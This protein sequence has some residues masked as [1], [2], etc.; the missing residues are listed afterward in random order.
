M[1]KIRNPYVVFGLKTLKGRNR[2]EDFRVDC[3]FLMLFVT[4]FEDYQN[5]VSLNHVTF[6]RNVT[7]ML[8]IRPHICILGLMRRR[9]DRQIDGEM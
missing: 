6:I 7:Y 9:T 3:D 1:E 5:M 8:S 4:E 2:V